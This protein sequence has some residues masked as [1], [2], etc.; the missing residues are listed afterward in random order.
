LSSKLRHCRSI[1]DTQGQAAPI[2]ILSRPSA[3]QGRHQ[4]SSIVDKGPQD[5]RSSEDPRPP[6]ETQLVHNSTQEVP[7]CPTCQAWSS[8]AG[9]TTVKERLPKKASRPLTLLPLRERTP[10]IIIYNTGI[11]KIGSCTPRLATRMDLVSLKSSHRP[12][13]VP[14]KEGLLPSLYPT[15]HLLCTRIRRATS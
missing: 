4:Q 9:A 7:S 13:K 15:T 11:R 10:A 12:L 14:P 2:A 1:K 5:R 6:D 8:K 3:T